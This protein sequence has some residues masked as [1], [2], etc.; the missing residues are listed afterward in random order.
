VF[1]GEEECGEGGGRRGCR[2]RRGGRG[3]GEGVM[4]DGLFTLTHTDYVFLKTP[5]LLSKVTY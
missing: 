2:G 5:N 3:A 1:E 4:T